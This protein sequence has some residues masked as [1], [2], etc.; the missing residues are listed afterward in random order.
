MAPTTYN[1]LTGK[2]E[3]GVEKDVLAPNF[4]FTMPP[5]ASSLDIQSRLDGAGVP[6]DESDQIAA[7]VGAN[8]E[9]E[10]VSKA[11]VTS[12]LQDIIL[13]VVSRRKAQESI[14]GD[15]ASIANEKARI[16]KELEG[17]DSV[18][19]SDALGTGIVSVLPILLGAALA[20]KKGAYAGAEAGLGG[21]ALAMKNIAQKQSEKDALNKQS[22][23]DLTQEERDKRKELAGSEESTAD[24]LGKMAEQRMITDRT[25][26][27]NAARD[28]L[29]DKRLGSTEKQ[30]ELDRVQKE[31]LQTEGEVFQLK[32]DAAKQSAELDLLKTKYN[33]EKDKLSFKDK[34]D[35]ENAFALKK[36]DFEYND[37][38]LKQKLQQLDSSQQRE[39][40]LKRELQ[41]NQFGHEDSQ[42]AQKQKFEGV[43]NAKKYMREKDL[44]EQR[45]GIQKDVANIYA[46]SRTQ[47][48]GGMATEEDKQMAANQL[49]QLGYDE[50]SP[51]V[52]TVFHNSTTVAGLQRQVAEL[53]RIKELNNKMSGAYGDIPKDIRER[54]SKANL[55]S[56]KIDPIIR[57]AKMVQRGSPAA[58][59]TAQKFLEQLPGTMQQDLAQEITFLA[60]NVGSDLQGKQL[61]AMELQS[62][63]DWLG[64][65]AQL[66]TGVIFD[67]LNRL[68][69][70]S[71]EDAQFNVRA[72]GA[73]P[74]NRPLMQSLQREFPEILVPIP[75]GAIIGTMDGVRGYKTQDG[76]FTAF[77]DA[78]Q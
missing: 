4:T 66:S 78:I 62:I 72:F 63:I 49:R 2:F 59:Y 23:K 56:M 45:G 47:G 35:L 39:I 30:N 14:K 37:N 52:T 27:S 76:K 11:P 77:N 54:V 50:N 16:R 18:S 25:D 15:L 48:Q 8:P 64:G 22:L 74:K 40:S 32:R 73:A 68:K 41:G 38:L 21:G 29:L 34:L 31:R 12:K 7:Q 36:Q 51:E 70:Q 53:R 57:A 1:P 6:P 61:N 44:V 17:T 28:D 58:T 67:R 46:N 13:P 24:Y 43:E 33:L 5:G 19:G 69:L 26:R 71:R 20:G 75:P 60:T 9:Q 3:E 10:D 65:R 42:L 55:I